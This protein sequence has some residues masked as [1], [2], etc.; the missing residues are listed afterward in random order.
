MG[1]LNAF[2]IL[3]EILQFRVKTN[4]PIDNIDTIILCDN[5]AVVNSVNK[6][7]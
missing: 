7:T 3:E 6:F 4:K 1:M 5:K 2:N